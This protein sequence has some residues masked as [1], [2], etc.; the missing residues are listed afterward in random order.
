MLYWISIA[1]AS[2]VHSHALLDLYSHHIFKLLPCNTGSV[3]PSHPVVTSMQYWICIS[4][5]S[6]S[7]FHAIVDH[8]VHWTYPEEKKK[9]QHWSVVYREETRMLYWTC[10]QVKSWRYSQC[11]AGALYSNRMLKALVCSTG[12]VTR[13][14]PADTPVL[15]WSAVHRSHSATR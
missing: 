14:R 5:T 10:N 3:H 2:R 12:S 7:Y 15:D 11:N 1:I 8:S 6:W 4:I 13:S 9:M